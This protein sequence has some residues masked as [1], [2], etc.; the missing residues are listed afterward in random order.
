MGVRSGIR[1]IGDRCERRKEGGRERSWG[2][3]TGYTGVHVFL[4]REVIWMFILRVRAA[5]VRRMKAR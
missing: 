1:L 4:K 3:K 2:R 5:T